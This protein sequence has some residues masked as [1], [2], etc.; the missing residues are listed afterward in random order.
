MKE[1]K[2]LP[3]LTITIPVL[4]EEKT[5]I[6]RIEIL[7]AHIKSKLSNKVS[8]SIVI[9]DNGSNDK[10]LELGNKLSEE[11]ENI[12]LIS[13]KEKGVGLALKKSWSKYQSEIMGYMDLDLAT[14][15]SHIEEAVDIIL[16]QDHKVVNG[17]RLMKESK[18]HG[19]KFIRNIASITFNKI[20][21]LLFNV[22]FSDGMCGFKFFQGDV[23]GILGGPK[24]I[25]SNG[26]FFA[27]EFL[28]L[29]E[30][31]NIKIKDIPVKWTDDPHSKVK[32]IKLTFQY[33]YEMMLLKL[34]FYLKK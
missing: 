17:S 19:R 34:R 15:L 33:L 22:K 3:N 20:L 4:N 18:V 12:Y 7:Q 1:K 25:H 8:T 14:D 6:N 2:R 26:W 27:T 32:I 30:S 16:N 9:A 29:L 11:N 13:I 24:S 28:I 23:M 10:T 31:S 21:K 5:L